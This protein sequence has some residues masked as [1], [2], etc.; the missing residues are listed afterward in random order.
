MTPVGAYDRTRY[1]Y[2]LFTKHTTKSFVRVYTSR[3]PRPFTTLQQRKTL[4]FHVW[5]VPRLLVDR[6][7]AH[8][9]ERFFT[10]F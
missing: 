9:N 8:V 3:A 2:N 6:H 4:P 5:Q 7:S 1:M 10:L